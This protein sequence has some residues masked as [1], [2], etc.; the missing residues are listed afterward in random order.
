MLLFDM[1]ESAAR[2][3]QR[4]HL[5][6]WRPPT[7]AACFLPVSY[8]LPLQNVMII[9]PADTSDLDSLHRLRNDYIDDS[10][11]TF[12]ENSM[13]RDDVDLWLHSYDREGPYRL[14]VA[15][16]KKR[17]LGFAGSQAYRHHPAFRKTIETSV[18]VAPG[19]E[20]RGIGSALYEALFE[21][22]ANEDLHRA[23]AGIALPN[24]ASVRLHKK[25]GFAEVGTFDEYAIKHD[26]YIS[27]V[28][29]QRSLRASR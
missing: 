12:D 14:Q 28:W 11:A 20:R 10:Y 24:E 5:I 18:Y 13:T 4:G 9:R 8:F 22:L 26:R 27:S 17:L 3:L 2:S 16:D 21:A 23:V 29:M 1:G 25:M 15:T 19:H 6:G 7:G